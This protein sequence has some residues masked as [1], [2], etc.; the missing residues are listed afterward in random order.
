MN[1]GKGSDIQH[2][3]IKTG[4]ESPSTLIQIKKK[5]PKHLFCEFPPCARGLGGKGGLSTGNRDRR[6]PQG[7]YSL[8]EGLRLEHTDEC[9]LHGCGDSCEGRGP[10]SDQGSGASCPRK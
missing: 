8:V 10:A 3:T 4:W 9:A 7:A 5:S 6:G 1:L 2:F